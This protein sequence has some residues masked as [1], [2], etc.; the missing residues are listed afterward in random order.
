MPR[1]KLAAICRSGRN[2]GVSFWMIFH[3]SK[4]QGKRGELTK[5][6]VAPMATAPVHMN[7]PVTH[8]A[9]LAYLGGASIATLHEDIPGQFPLPSRGVVSL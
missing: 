8:A 6:V 1:R 3:I 7:H 9:P 2:R 4:G 5:L